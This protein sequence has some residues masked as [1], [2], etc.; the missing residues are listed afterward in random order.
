MSTQIAE[1]AEPGTSGSTLLVGPDEKVSWGQSV[2]LGLQH[3]LAM[4]VYVVPFIV[5][6]ILALGAGESAA[7]IRSTFITAG[8]ATII[9]TGLLMRIPMAQG[10]SYIP[11]GALAGITIAAGGGL[12]GWGTAMGAALIGALVV[13]ALGLTGLFHR[14]IEYF[15]PALVGGTIIFCIGLSLMPSALNENIFRAPGASLE[16]N[17]ILAGVSGGT[18]LVLSVLG[19]HLR[20]AGSFFR[21]ASVILALFAGS[22]VAGGMG[23]LNLTPVA[24]AGWFELPLLPFVDFQ[25][26]FNPAAIITMLIIYLVLMAETT[27]TWLTISNVIGKPL[28][29]E[30]LDRGVVG[31]GLGCTIASLLG[32]TPVTGYSSNAG[33]ITITGVA[34]RRVFMMTGA[35]FVVFGLSGKLSALIS[36]IPTAVVGGVFALVCGVISV[37]GFQV[38]RRLTI[39]QKETYVIVIPI[40]AVLALTFLPKEF[41]ATQP[42]I[43]QYLLGSPI[44]IAS[45]AAIILNKALP[46]DLPAG[47]QLDEAA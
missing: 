24:E 38:L 13:T 37:G 32:S 30:H 3:L 39:G 46:A 5:A 40:L 44:A 12:Q 1:D 25:F 41:I 18:M 36:S 29:R 19:N 47:P 6:T 14:F 7:L 11:I 17:L 15:V 10:A 42:E 35:L 16:Q 27:G 26:A 20:G 9:Q 4:D 34:S 21:I 28:Q 43:L 2:V 23:I 22:V 31:E 45:L 33:I 8:L